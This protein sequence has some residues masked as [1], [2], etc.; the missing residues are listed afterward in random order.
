MPTN[1]VHFAGTGHEPTTTPDYEAAGVKVLTTH[2][3]VEMRK[4][5]T[6]LKQELRSVFVAEKDSTRDAKPPR[7]RR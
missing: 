3:R 5:V 4:T 7:G 2:T 6:R 1:K